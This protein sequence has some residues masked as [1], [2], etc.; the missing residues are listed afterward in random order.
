MLARPGGDVRVPARVRR[1]RVAWRVVGGESR[2][3]TLVVPWWARRRVW[4]VVARRARGARRAEWM[5]FIA[6]A[7]SLDVRISWPLRAPSLARGG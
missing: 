6:T 3:P 4:R 1:W 7:L 5:R 2:P